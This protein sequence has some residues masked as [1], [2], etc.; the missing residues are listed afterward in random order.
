MHRPPPI[1]TLFPYT[2]LFR[3]VEGESR[4][5]EVQ[6]PGVGGVDGTELLR[7][8]RQFDQPNS[9][10]RPQVPRRVLGQP[11]PAVGGEDRKS[12]RLDS[13]HPVIS[14]AV[15]CL[16]KKITHERTG[17]VWMP[18]FSAERS[19]GVTPVEPTPMPT[20]LVL[21]AIE[22]ILLSSTVLF[23]LAGSTTRP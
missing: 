11:L 22:K 10:A 9:A 19:C 17:R 21:L 6:R 14:Y 3:S 12:T 20:P 15:L 4:I 13:S 2:P 1:S 23:A 18:S 8:R 16:K 7:T 5:A